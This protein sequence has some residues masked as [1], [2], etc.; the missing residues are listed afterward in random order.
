MENTS[1]A[2]TIYKTAETPVTIPLTQ[3]TELVCKANDLENIKS[4]VSGCKDGSYIDSDTAKVIKVLCGLP[5]GK[6]T[7]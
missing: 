2:T 6:E 5:F 1:G 4:I 7:K 3:Y